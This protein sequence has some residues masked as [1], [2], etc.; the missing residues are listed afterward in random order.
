MAERGM[1]LLEVRGLSV[2]FGER[3]ALEGA[4]L[5]LDAGE[6][7]ALVG[8]SGSG[9]STL[10]LALLGI[11]EPPGRVERGSVRLGGRELFALERAELDGLRGAEIGFVF[12]EPQTAL[13]PVL[14]IGEQVAE[15]LRA[16]RGLSRAE[17]WRAAVAALAE[18][19]LPD[20]ERAARS[21]PH[22]LSGGMR[23]RALIAIAVAPAPRVL[24][25]DEPTTALDPTVAQGVL[26]L[27]ARLRRERGLALV[28]VSHDLGLVARVA[29]RVLV[30]ERGSIVERGAP[31]ELFE[32][33]A[34]PATR[35][36]VAAARAA[37]AAGGL[38]LAR[39][40]RAPL[41]EVRE[42]EV[43]HRGRPRFFGRARGVPAVRG[44]S[45]EVARGE[46]L[47]VVGESGSGKS[48]LARARGRPGRSERGPRAAGRA[49][50]RARPAR[51]GAP[52]GSGSS[53]RTRARAS[54]RATGSSAIVGE[55]LAVHRLAR[56]P[57][58]SASAWRGCSS[59]SAWRATWRS[60][61]RTSSPAA[62]A[63]AWPSRARW[64]SSPSSWCSTKPP[65]RSTRP[66]AP[67]VLDAARDAACASSA[68]RCSSSPTT[69]PPCA[70]LAD[71][72]AVMYLGRVVELGPRARAPRRPG[73]SLH[74]RAARRRRGRRHA[75]A[76]C[77]RGE[78]PAPLAPPAGLRLPSALP[79]RRG[80]LPRARARRGRERRAPRRAATWSSPFRVRPSRAGGAAASGRRG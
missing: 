28:L 23:Q 58:R 57:S 1:P 33:A 9:K 79:A 60:A 62:S 54:T 43:V 65:R 21:F 48:S 69:S 78:A 71:R 44:V 4:D 59:A 35:A 50:P 18:V 30:L 67:Q 72:V 51:R 14:T 31:A 39:S 37:P 38:A 7:L 15:G 26:E 36:L 70:H 5:E 11:V 32:R 56:G 24:V 45:F 16:H 34:H 52:R 64:R 75:P 27:F 68:W 80:P 17:A 20:P 40:G 77:S 63:S 61:G 19:G 13:D 66:C 41:L 25:A 74:A 46:V 8:A 2:R 6:T 10:A 76:A 42:L 73:P 47:A 55:A 12:Q 3:V 29:D 53:S 22:Q 49:A